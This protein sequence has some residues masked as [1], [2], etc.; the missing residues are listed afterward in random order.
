MSAHDALR[1]MREGNER[2][3]SNLPGAAVGLCYGGPNDDL[4]AVYHV[5]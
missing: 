2:F 3:A 1:R 5:I 4:Y